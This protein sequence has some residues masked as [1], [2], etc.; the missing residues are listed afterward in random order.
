MTLDG[1][2]DVIVSTLV[3]SGFQATPGAQWP[4]QQP[5]PVLYERVG[6]AGSIPYQQIGFF[7][8]ID[9]AGQH[10]LWGTWTG[11]SVPFGPAA[12]DNNGNAIAAGN[13]AGQGDIT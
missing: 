9:A 6:F 7:G 8:K 4:C 12:V 13:V 5:A 2:G 1:S 3:P 11:P 10:L